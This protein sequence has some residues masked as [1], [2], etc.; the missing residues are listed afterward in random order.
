M[1]GDLCERL[2]QITLSEVKQLHVMFLWG[3]MKYVLPKS[4]Y[5]TDPSPLLLELEELR[6][7]K[8]MIIYEAAFPDFLYEVFTQT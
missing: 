6:L 4:P 1:L 3:Q 7:C 5:E 2:R 8:P